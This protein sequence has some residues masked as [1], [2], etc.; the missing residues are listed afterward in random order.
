[1]KIKSLP[2]DYKKAFKPYDIRGIYPNEIDEEV[3]YRAGR[4]YIQLFKFKEMFVGRDMRLSSPSLSKAFIQGILDQGANVTDIGIV[5][6]PLVYY[7]SGKYKKAGAMVT[8]SHNAKQYNGIKL[9]KKGAVATSWET[10][11]KSIMEL[12]EKNKFSSVKKKGKYRKKDF[13][14]EYV[15][16][17]GKFEKMVKTKKINVVVGAG[18][19]MASKIVPPV[20]KNLNLKMT[21]V[22]F[23]LD[24]SFPYHIPNPTIEKNRK[25]VRKMVV[26]K[27]ADFGISFD[28][29]MDRVVFFDEKGFP[30][31]SS[32]I[33]SLLT[34][35]YLKNRKATIGY[36]SLTSKILLETIKKYKGKSYRLK[37]GQS[38]VKEGMRKSN[39]IFGAE[40]SAHFYFKDFYYA[41]SGIITSL[42]ILNI[43][44]ELIKEGKKFSEEIDEFRKYA[45]AEEVLLK[46]KDKDKVLKAVEAYYDKKKPIKKDHFDFLTIWF[47]D[48][49]FNVK[50]SGTEDALK[51]NLEADNK[52]IM[53]TKLKELLRIVKKV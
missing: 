37:V 26:K 47:K 6:T 1:M 21:K 41:D 9:V 3:A 46:V 10:G 11:F 35:Q 45:Q 5:D 23:G 2:K 16:Y 19:G 34:K 32:V 28:G 27:K 49:W 33:A 50:K 8:A 7:A 39:A 29:D 43:V 36:T 22:H 52:R 48:Y 17:L 44:S 15:N 42:L 13:L 4:A 24:G 14:K 53:K 18:S 25:L 12:A 31:S 38:L 20:Y 30:I 40:H 51:V